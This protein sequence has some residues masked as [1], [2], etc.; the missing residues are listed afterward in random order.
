MAKYI[1][2]DPKALVSNGSDQTL[3]IGNVLCEDCIPV[4][5]FPREISSRRKY[6]NQLIYDNNPTLLSISLSNEPQVF[7][8]AL[9]PGVSLL[10]V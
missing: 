2:G 5:H 8:Y 10:T 9:W 6:A 4:H 7:K 1:L 3:S